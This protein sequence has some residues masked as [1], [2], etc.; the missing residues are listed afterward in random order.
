MLGLRRAG[1]SA[2]DRDEI[3]RAFKLLY[4]SGLNTKQALEKAA[5]M[6]F[7]PWA[8]EFFNFVA[9]AGKRGIVSYRRI[10]R[11]RL[12][13]PVPTSASGAL[14]PV[15]VDASR[16]RSSQ[17]RQHSA[18]RPFFRAIRIVAIQI[19][20]GANAAVV[21]GRDPEIAALPHDLT[22]KICFIMRRTNARTE[23]H[24]EIRRA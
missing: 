2:A 16:S 12:V 7:G 20:R 13:L 24:N 22:G 14:T 10:R 8:R 15:H 18:G 11:R 4:R 17:E 5:E 9:R 23:L 6:E 19:A 21:Y 1:F 3:R